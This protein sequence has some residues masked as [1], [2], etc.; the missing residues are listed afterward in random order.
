MLPADLRAGYDRFRATEYAMHRARYDA[1]AH[2]QSPATMIVSCADSRVDPAAI[3]DAAPGELFVI[4]NLANLVPP[5]ERGGGQHGV[6]SAV[7]FAVL[8]LKVRQ[9]V[10]M[11]HA[12][13]GGVNAALHGHHLAP[14]G[15]SFL[16][17]WIGLLAPARARIEG[18][19]DLQRALELESVRVSLANL[20][21]FPFV[22]Q[23]EAAGRLT[24]HGAHFGIAEGE[25][26]EV[27]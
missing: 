25:L 6:S 1:L 5:F 20:R 23:A 24:L 2:G 19:A 21:S 27:A 7:E 12:D 16:T 8:G 14:E 3:F 11:G 22:A 17:K 26:R 18:A 13:C 4:R 9:I 10:I 15:E